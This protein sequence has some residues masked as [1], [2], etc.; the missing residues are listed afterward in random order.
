MPQMD[1]DFLDKRCKAFPSPWDSRNYRVR[2]PLLA[3]I[4]VLPEEFD[5]LKPF[6]DEDWYDQGNWGSCVGWDG[7]ITMEVTNHVVDNI[8][9]ELS[10]WWLYHRSRFY[11]GLPPGI[12]G[13]TNAGLMKALNH[14]GVCLESCCPTPT[15]RR[16]SKFEPCNDAYDQ[17]KLFSIDSYWYVNPIPSDMMAAI[18]GVTHPA[19]YDMPDGSPGKIPLITAFPVY[20]SFSE[21]YEN[22]VVPMPRATDTLRGGHSSPIT[23]WKLID[24]E[25]YWINPG[26]WGKEVGDNGTFYLPFGYPFY[27]AWIIHNGEKVK[28]WWCWWLGWVPW[29]R[30][31]C[32]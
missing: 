9:D 2:S 7:K 24:G 14:E 20:S 15:D 18:Y 21:G 1:D 12:E 30:E 19:P 17:A 6:L 13:S 22:G 25:V 29:F 16:Y 28:P 4:E 10:A 32:R 11:A 5:G 3:E 8:P 27:D 31:I 26:S 23:G